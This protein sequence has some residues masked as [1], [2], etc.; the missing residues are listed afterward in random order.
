VNGLLNPSF[1]IDSNADGIADGWTHGGNVAGTPV[2]TLVA[3]RLGGFAQR[4][5]YIGVAEDIDAI[6]TFFL[7]A[8]NGVPAAPNDVVTASIHANLV[9]PETCAARLRHIYWGSDNGYVSEGTSIDIPYDGAPIWERYA[10]SGVIPADVAKTGLWVPL[11]GINEGDVIELLL[12]DSQIEKSPFPT[13]YFDGSTSDSLN[14]NTYAWTGAA[15]ASTS[16]R[17]GSDLYLP[18]S[19]GS[20]AYTIAAR[21][22]GLWST[23][24]GRG[25]EIATAFKGSDP[26]HSLSLVKHSDN[27]MYG[28]P[29]DGTHNPLTNVSMENSAAGTIHTAM[30]SGTWGG[31]AVT[32]HDGISG[33]VV[34]ISSVNQ[35]GLDFLSL[36]GIST[37]ITS[38]VCDSYLGPVLISPQRKSDAWTVAMDALLRGES[39]D[40]SRIKRDFMSPGDALFTGREID[41]SHLYVKGA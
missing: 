27:N 26:S 33:V 23:H 14:A 16:T 32:S 28:I 7:S 41:G 31:T 15:N 39:V 37:G 22:I 24:D 38:V 1:D 9:M 30:T 5:Q 34:D 8:A 11:E 13:P 40:I 17:A 18:F 12:D 20:S 21:Y 35:P 2:F 6:L 19:F 10:S 36:S 29:S 4:V 3:G 25:H